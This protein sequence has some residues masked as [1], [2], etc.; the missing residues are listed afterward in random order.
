MTRNSH[1]DNKNSFMEMFIC[2][3]LNHNSLCKLFMRKVISWKRTSAR[4]HRKRNDVVYVSRM[5]IASHLFLFT[6]AIKRKYDDS[7]PTLK[8]DTR[9][10]PERTR[11][12][13]QNA[14][15]VDATDE[16][17][18]EIGEIILLCRHAQQSADNS[19]LHFSFFVH[20]PFS[21]GETDNIFPIE[22]RK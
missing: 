21:C 3:G 6:D 11:L 5:I 13:N 20:C 19:L 7:F 2:A 22:T 9:Q 12:D 8:R 1:V 17:D 4:K 16:Y 10:Q 18:I 15:F 14:K